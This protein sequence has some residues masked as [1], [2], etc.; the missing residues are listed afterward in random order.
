MRIRKGELG[1][2]SKVK[3]I[4]LIYTVSV[5]CSSS[6]IQSSLWKA[7]CIFMSQAFPTVISVLTIQSWD[8]SFTQIPRR[9]F[10]LERMG[11]LGNLEKPPW[12]E[13]LQK[14]PAPSQPWTS[15]SAVSA[16]WSQ[17][18]NGCVQIK[19]ISY[20]FRGGVHFL[21]DFKGLFFGLRGNR[22]F[23]EFGS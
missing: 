7:W 21:K 17:T 9:T 20:K 18:N 11:R 16:S 6:F 3:V 19:A 14:A 2:V 5:H 1:V 15:R 22:K 12:W 13:P 4:T 23:K 8:D 10:S